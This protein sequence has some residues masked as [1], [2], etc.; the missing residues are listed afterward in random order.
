MGEPLILDDIEQRILGS[1]LE[2]QSTVPASYPLTLNALRTACNQTSSREPVSDYSV[3]DLEQALT[4]LRSRGLVRVVWS[5]SGRRTL[6]YHQLLDDVLELQPDQRAVITVLLLRGAQAPGEL[7]TRTDRLHAFGDRAAV[8]SVLEELAK[9]P[10]PL[11][12]ELP[13]RAGH[14]DARWI[15]LLGP[16]DES[17]QVDVG[18]P[19]PDRE[20]VLADG[21][22]RRD[23]R[24]VSSYDA[25]AAAYADHVEE[26]SRLSAF[27][28]WLLGRVGEWAGDRPVADVG[29]GLG[30]LAARMNDAGVTAR[31]FDLSP[32]MVSEARRRFPNV[33]FEVGDLRTLLKPRD[34]DGWGVVVAWQC[35]L[36]FAPSE[37]PAVFAAM[38]RA[39]AVNGTLLLA[40]DVGSEVGHR[41]TW[42]EAS[43]DLDLVRHDPDQLLRSVEKAGL[44]V[45][46]WYLHGPLPDRDRGGRKVYVVARPSTAM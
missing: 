10:T 24:V 22:A 34:A 41:D 30:Q 44:T 32:G 25:V 15:H 13:R 8:E 7:K 35:L 29:C 23:H 21:P 4:A 12:R 19:Q 1:L 42:W 27:E 46:E 40:A 36:H 18:E 43:V 16:V 26:D 14:H 45:I 39:L 9:R 37:L 31:G 17:R 33:E 5:E 38:S 28:A 3:S 6:K 11:V 20:T 2:K